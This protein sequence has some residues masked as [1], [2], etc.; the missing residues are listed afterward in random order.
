MSTTKTPTAQGISRL[1]A[2][3]GFKRSVS[4]TTRI[5]G[6]HDWNEGFKVEGGYWDGKIV[7]R[8]VMDKGARGDAADKRRSDAL[9]DYTKVI[10]EAGYTAERS[11]D[12]GQKLIVTAIGSSEGNDTNE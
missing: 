7:V 2:K 12:F 9:D 3:A 8:H 1:L 4:R 6:W 10:T 5:R 11:S